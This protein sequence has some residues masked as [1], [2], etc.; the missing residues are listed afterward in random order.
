MNKVHYEDLDEE[1]VYWGEECIVDKD[2]MLEYNLKNDPWPIHVDKELDAQSQF[3]GIIAS[4]GYTI[5]LLYR[6]NH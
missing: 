5:T 2:K 4:G 1:S 6:F 3:A